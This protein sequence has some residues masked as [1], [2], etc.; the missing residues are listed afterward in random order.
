V[1]ALPAVESTRAASTAEQI[2]DLAENL[3]QT[4]GYS[5]FSYQDISAAL[6]IRKASIHYHYASKTELGI[7]VLDRYVARFDAALKRIAADP[8][9]SSKRMLDFY[10]EPYLQ[11]ARTSDQVCLCGALAGEMLT[12][13]AEMRERV[14]RFFQAHQQWLA[15]TL[16][17]GTTRGEFTLSTSPAKAARLFFGAL[18]GALLVK[19]TTGDPSQLRDVV[20]AIRAQLESKGRRLPAR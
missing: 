2:L 1:T 20:E 17:R 15:T 9:Q 4:R 5:W 16:K 8:A 18:Q 19:R 14:D 12:L 3:I 11:F 13:P 6:G 7:A 10:F